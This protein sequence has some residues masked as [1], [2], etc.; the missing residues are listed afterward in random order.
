MG[1]NIIVLN[2][3]YSYKQLMNFFP[4]NALFVSLRQPGCR[5]F[6]NLVQNAGKD[7][8][9]ICN[10]DCCTKRYLQTRNVCYNCMNVR[11]MYKKFTNIFR[12]RMSRNIIHYGGDHFKVEDTNRQD[13][14][15]NKKRDGMGSVAAKKIRRSACFCRVRIFF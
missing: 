5:Q 12:C 3:Q 2:L 6:H 14:G 13:V 4:L 15:S 10:L 7:L 11:C 9:F 8:S 1:I